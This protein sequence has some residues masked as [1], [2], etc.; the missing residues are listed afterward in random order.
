MRRSPSIGITSLRGSTYRRDSRRSESLEGLSRSPK[1]IVRPNG[2][3]QVR[4][5]PPCHFAPSGLADGLFEQVQAIL[6]PAPSLRFQR[7]LNRAFLQS[8]IGRLFS[9]SLLRWV[10]GC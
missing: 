8:V 9:E 7:Y 2:P 1:S 6:A 4:F 3:H 10:R 5:V